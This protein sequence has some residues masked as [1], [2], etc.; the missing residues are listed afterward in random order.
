MLHH[1]E[2][3]N[4]TLVKVLFMDCADARFQR[5]RQVDGASVD[6]EVART[7]MTNRLLREQIYFLVQLNA[8]GRGRL[9]ETT[10]T[11]EEFVD[12]LGSCSRSHYH[13]EGMLYWL[14]RYNPE[15]WCK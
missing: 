1:I 5:M 12:I 4:T 14:L 11:K 8:C 15:V 2:R 13:D 7:R 6:N 3:F 10:L 9:R